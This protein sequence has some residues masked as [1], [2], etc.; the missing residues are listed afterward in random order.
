MSR[1]RVVITGLGGLTSLG[2]GIEKTWEGLIQGRS[3]I[4][5]VSR[6]DA[7]AFATRFA[8]E[9]REYDAANFFPK[10]ESKKLDIFTQYAVLAA[11]E[12][13]K[14]ARIDLDACDRD[15]V[16]CIMGSG[17]GGINELES[18]HS[19]YL[20]K[21]A[22]RISPH[23]IPKLMVNAMSG[24]ISIRHGLR[25]TNFV[26]GSAC[27]S[28]GHAIGMALRALQYGEQDVILTGGSETAITPLGLGG[29]CAL[30]AL[31]TRNEDPEGA[32]RPF[33]K[34]RDGFVLGEG[35]AIAVLEEFEHAR[36]RDATIYAEV[37]GFGSSA[38]AFH[39]TAPKE[40]G[41]GPAR[42]MK[43]ALDDGRIPLEQV[44]YINAH[45]TSTPY[46]DAIETRA[47]KGVF[48]PHAKKLAVSSTKSMIGHL[49]GASAAV[50]FAVTAKTVYH[51]VV[52]PTR[53]LQNPD[54]ECDLDYVPGSARDR[55][56]RFALS[57]SLGFGGHNVSLL[58]G[59]V[60]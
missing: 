45:G 26:T 52:H 3:G 38:D 5:P 18:M 46:N 39:I 8:G 60:R 23:F 14:D 16:G 33:D 9:C 34:D 4:G 54:P 17:I 35:A 1:K 48:G 10:V 57:N 36:R 27:A 22:S 59:K 29:F 50:E 6:F 55:N 12:A 11:D 42:A 20:E 25:G 49:L 31:S 28:A 2:I 44:D 47:I 32:S 43:L 7:S 53:N 37:L 58:L 51:N 30:R 24:V 15:R 40:D 19:V 13:L 41:L 56:V 21:G